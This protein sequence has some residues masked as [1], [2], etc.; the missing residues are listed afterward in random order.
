MN[1]LLQKDSTRR[2]QSCEEAFTRLKN[3]FFE[4]VTLSFPNFSKPLIF[5]TDASDFGIGA[6]LSQRNQTNVE[7][8][9]A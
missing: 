2:S 5:D 3:A 1:K 8:P 4:I 7:Q 6:V 9:I